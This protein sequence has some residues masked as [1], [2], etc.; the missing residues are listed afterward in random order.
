MPRYDLTRATSSDAVPGPAKSATSSSQ[1]RRRSSSPL[2]DRR[3][4]SLS[5]S[6]ISRHVGKL[7]L[8]PNGSPTMGQDPNTQVLN[9]LIV[10]D[11]VINRR[12][13]V[14]FM[15][16]HNFK[17]EEA[18]NGME[19]VEAYRKAKSPRFDVILMGKYHLAS[20]PLLGFT[21]FYR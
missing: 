8:H 5:E 13:L 14:A 9:V 10:D 18:A 17:F 2:T 19:A 6:A 15:K 20:F 11:N 4:S 3:I 21:Y 7:D 12:L 1:F 16:K